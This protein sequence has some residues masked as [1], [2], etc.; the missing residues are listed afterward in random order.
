MLRTFLSFGMSIVLVS[1]ST[2]ER[3]NVFS[4]SSIQKLDSTTELDE[5]NFSNPVLINGSSIGEVAQQLY[6]QGNWPELIKFIS[7]SSIQEF[8][9]ENIISSFQRTDFG[10]EIQLKSMSIFGE[11]QYLLNYHTW[12]FG[13][14]GIL[15]MGIVIENDTAKIVIKQINPTIQFDDSDDGTQIPY[16]GC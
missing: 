3:E 7:D 16:F 6:K 10:Y 8:G 13:T 12:K 11:G 5:T 15:R 4:E 2:S 9:E 1:C 14:K